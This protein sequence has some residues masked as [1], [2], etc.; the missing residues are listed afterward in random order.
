MEILRAEDLTFTYPNQSRAALEEI[1]FS[2]DRGEFVTLCGKSGSG[3]STLL[4]QFKPSVAPH[5]VRSGSIY[6][7]N[8]EQSALSARDEASKL[9]FIGQSP[10]DQIV[11]D[12]VWHELAFGLESLGEPTEKIRAKV[13]ETA[14]YFGISDWFHRPTD[15]LSGG[16][17]QLLCLAAV[18]VMQPELLLL[19]EP[20]A[21][22]DPIAAHSFLQ[23]L[24]RVCRELG[25]TVILSEHRLEEAFPL[26]DRVIVMENG[27]IFSDE[28]PRLVA[29]RLYQADNEMFRALPTPARVYAASESAV[30]SS[31]P[32]TVR[33]GR[34]WLEDK[35]LDPSAI[36]ERPEPSYGKSILQAKNLFFRY[37]KSAPDV[38]SDFSLTLYEGEIY[39]LVGANGAGKSTALAVLCGMKKPFHGSVMT[40]GKKTAL[41]PQEPLDLFFGKNVKEDLLSVADIRSEEGRAKYEETVRLF[42]LETLLD[43]HPYDLSGGER[44]KAAFAKL[45]LSGAEIL[46]LDE[47]TKGLDAPFK[48]T[49]AA[50]M[51]T[52]KECGISILMVSHD[53]EFCAESADRC[54]L[55]FDGSIVSEN[56]AHR[57]F[58]DNLYYTTAAHRMAA[59]LLPEAVTDNDILAALGKRTGQPT[60]KEPQTDTSRHSEKE[61]Q[62]P[63]VVQP[64]TSEPKSAEPL[65]TA[66]MQTAQKNATSLIPAF[67]WLVF[68]IPLTVLCGIYLFDDRKYLFISLLI[69][70]ETALP[71]AMRF[72]KRKPTVTELVILA[73]LCA[74]G[75]A[76]RVAFFKIPQFKPVAALVI[77]SGVCFGGEYGF[78]VGALTAFLSNFFFGQGPWTPWQMFAFGV[79]GLLAGALFYPPKKRGLAYKVRLCL[80]GFFTVLIGYGVLLDTATVLMATPYPTLSA[81][82]TAFAAGFP[83]NL[84]HALATV[85]FLFLFAEPMTEKL[86]RVKTKYGIDN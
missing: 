46:L 36:P 79:I 72:E 8:A 59:S 9:G 76:G 40:D 44:Q 77:V 78:L 22:L 6:F 23:S 55:F 29:H 5:G 11:T 12:R 33:E 4:R 2:V 13:A 39:A 24:S 16:E 82:L 63:S 58:A 52:L 45:L 20:T 19:D 38:L 86:E 15:T 41:L 48:R 74:I 84:I 1:S 28:P 32:L 54:G 21:K 37:E 3:K 71:F 14:S 31:S 7:E 51:R 73:A 17:E 68:A 80:F 43:R 65:P 30:D 49:L 35:P 25:T 81:F 10:T 57:F 47:P 75:I 61:V 67:L 60:S 70:A 83:F 62:K 27:R 26:S 50:L 53:I 42:G 18:M 56:T 85:I 64:A 34:A 66:A 69:M